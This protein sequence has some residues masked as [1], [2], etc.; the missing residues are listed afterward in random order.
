MLLLHDRGV[1]L[2]GIFAALVGVED[3]WRGACAP[4]R[5][6]ECSEYEFRGVPEEHMPSEDL[7]GA[8]IHDRG[9]VQH[10]ASEDQVREVRD[11]DQVR[12]QRERDREEQVLVGDE[13]GDAP[14]MLALPASP[15]GVDAEDLHDALDLL[16]VQVERESE[17]PGAVARV[18]VED[19]LDPD[20]QG[21]VA[22]GFLPPIVQARTGNAESAGKRGSR[23]RHTRERPSFFPPRAQR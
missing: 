14:R 21:P 16:A 18:L 8:K 11:L 3:P 12:E 9:E 2:A 13:R 23:F 20:F 10:H 15:V 4:D 17:A 5:I 7:P 6:L 19:L 22:F 1:A